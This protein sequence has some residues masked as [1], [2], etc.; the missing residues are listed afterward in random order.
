MESL[1]LGIAVTLLMR[2]NISGIYSASCACGLQN[3]MVS[4]YT[5]SNI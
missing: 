4:T 5:S 2:D 1:L 3:A